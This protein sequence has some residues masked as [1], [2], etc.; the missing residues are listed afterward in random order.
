M[1]KA[2]NMSPSPILFDGLA[3]SSGYT[4]QSPKRTAVLGLTSY[5]GRNGD[6]PF[7]LRKESKHVF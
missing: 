2:P 6:E 7:L 1:I 4:L 3:V 5:S